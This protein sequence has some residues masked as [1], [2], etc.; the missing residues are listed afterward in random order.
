MLRPRLLFLHPAGVYQA[1]R[2][3]RNALIFQRVFFYPMTIL[4]HFQSEL[5]SGMNSHKNTLTS[6]FIFD[7]K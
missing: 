7:G 6:E 1:A 5:S 2:L 4:I 3:P